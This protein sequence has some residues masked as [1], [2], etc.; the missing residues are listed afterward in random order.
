MMVEELPSYLVPDPD[1]GETVSSWIASMYSFTNVARF[2]EITTSEMMT[3]QEIIASQPQSIGKSTLLNVALN[4]ETGPCGFLTL[5]PVLS[6][7]PQK[8]ADVHALR[9][10]HRCPEVYAFIGNTQPPR[11]ATIKMEPPNGMELYLKQTHKTYRDKHQ[12]D[13]F[14]RS[15]PERIRYFRMKAKESREGWEVFFYIP[16]VWVPAF[17]EPLLPNQA[18]KRVIELCHMMPE[19]SR[20]LFDEIREWMTAACTEQGGDG[21]DSGSSILTIPWRN[22]SIEHQFLLWA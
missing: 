11:L 15:N 22:V 10:C 16:T 19:S 18:R 5:L 21:P 17:T 8:V 6:D 13:T 9:Q 7:E 2:C 20:Y 1:N 14:Y 3:I 12:V 4:T